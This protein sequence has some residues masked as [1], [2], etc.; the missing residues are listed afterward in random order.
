MGLVY[1]QTQVIIDYWSFD[2]LDLGIEQLT[3]VFIDGETEQ[4]Q[5]LQ[6]YEQQQVIVYIFMKVDLIIELKQLYDL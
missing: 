6:V 5:D 3:S 4:L 1:K 2:L